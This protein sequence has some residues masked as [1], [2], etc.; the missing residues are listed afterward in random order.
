MLIRISTLKLDEKVPQLILLSSRTETG[1]EDVFKRLRTTKATPEFAFLLNNVFRKAMKGHMYRGFTMASPGIPNTPHK[2][3]VSDECVDFDTIPHF[4]FKFRGYKV[5]EKGLDFTH[6][7]LFS[8]LFDVDYEIPP[9][10]RIW[11]LI[12]NFVFSCLAVLF[13]GTLVHKEKF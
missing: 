2:T 10:V 4:N 6:G 3:V 9:G 7:I 12:Q 8:P 11:L 13:L 5:N 1:I